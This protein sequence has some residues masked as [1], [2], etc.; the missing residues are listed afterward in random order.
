MSNMNFENVSNLK[1]LLVLR[2]A[3]D[4]LQQGIQPD[5]N[6][7]DACYEDLCRE[8]VSF[9]LL[10]NIGDIDLSATDESSSVAKTIDEDLLNKV[11][12]QFGE[13]YNELIEKVQELGEK[14]KKQYVVD[15]VNDMRDKN[16]YNLRIWDDS[17][18]CYVRTYINKLDLDTN[19]GPD[20]KA[21]FNR[22]KTKVFNMSNKTLD[23]LT[24]KDYYNAEFGDKKEK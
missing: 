8:I 5:M 19:L 4:M 13:N 17:N 3:I 12:E 21:S 11:K 18:S 9:E 6:V 14:E 24:G 1:K 7:I 16:N 2:E 20:I 10:D 22:N 15:V 23:K